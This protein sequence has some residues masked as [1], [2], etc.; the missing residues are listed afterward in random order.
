MTGIDEQD[1]SDAVKRVEDSV[2]TATERV[3]QEL[4]RLDMGIGG[5]GGIIHRLS[6]I[7]DYLSELRA[8]AAQI[9]FILIVLTALIAYKIFA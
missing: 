8:H 9:K 3:E 6:D 7:H 5:S 1:I 2:D 4:R